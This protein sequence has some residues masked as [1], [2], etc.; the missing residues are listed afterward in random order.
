MGFDKEKEKSFSFCY[1]FVLAR[2]WHVGGMVV[3]FYIAWAVAFLPSIQRV[4]ECLRA[5][6]FPKYV[7]SIIATID[8][9]IHRAGVLDSQFAWH[10]RIFMSFPFRASSKSDKTQPDPFLPS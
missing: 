8:H 9:M 3:F 4:H 10:G 1:S 2:Q 7:I 6:L 5:P